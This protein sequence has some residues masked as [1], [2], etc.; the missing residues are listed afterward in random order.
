MTVRHNPIGLRPRLRRAS[1]GQRRE[2]I[3][4]AAA[5][6]GVAQMPSEAASEGARIAPV[7]RS[8][9][10][11]IYFRGQ[12]DRE[13]SRAFIQEMEKKPRDVVITSAGGDEFAAMEMGEAIL[14]YDR[15][16]TAE[17]YCLSGCFN[18]IL[19]AAKQR[20]ITPGTL[21]GV[22]GS[23]IALMQ[24]YAQTRREPPAPLPG[25]VDR[26]RRLYKAR[27]VDL[28]I[29]RCAA[30]QIGTTNLHVAD[31]RSRYGGWLTIYNLWIP[32]KADLQRFGVDTT[33]NDIL[34]KSREERRAFVVQAGLKP[35]A[36]LNWSAAPQSCE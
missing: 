19:V 27:G 18:T 23:A 31:E 30:I 22:H 21:V 24:R 3:L 32:S 28:D 7:V 17:R 29:L 2:F 12:I 9:D 25:L 6:V 33:G 5:L 4:L 20:I 8:D 34:P 15:S 36:R 35:A 14:K 13:Q 11:T 26:Y 16:V 1:C 10:T